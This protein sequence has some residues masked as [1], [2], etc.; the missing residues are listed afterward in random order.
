MS[1]R[2]LVVDNTSL[3]CG[4]WVT[5]TALKAPYAVTC[6]ATASDGALGVLRRR[7][8]A[9]TDYYGTAIAILEVVVAGSCRLWGQPTGVAITHGW[10]VLTDTEAGPAPDS[11]DMWDDV[12]DRS[13]FW[14]NTDPSVFIRRLPPGHPS[15]S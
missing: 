12:P 11:S 13:T 3:Q 1:V 4:K 7:V 6:S 9:G 5:V 14:A 15:S 10:W 8:F 2:V